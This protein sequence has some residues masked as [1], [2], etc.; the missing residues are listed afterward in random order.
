MTLNIGVDIEKISRF[1]LAGKSLLGKIF[2]GNELRNM[3]KKDFRHIAGMYC[4]K[5]AIIK[6]CNPVVRLGYLDI[7]IMHNKDGS[8]FPVIR[9]SKQIKIKELRVSISH[10]E[11]HAAAAAILSTR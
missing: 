7:E 8:P 4:A 1:R 9:K 3:R 5:E 10:T 2:T 6:A 11:D